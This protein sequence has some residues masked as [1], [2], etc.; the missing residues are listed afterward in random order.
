MERKRTVDEAEE[1]KAEVR[2]LHANPMVLVDRHLAIRYVNR[3]VPGLSA[4]EVLG[5]ELLEFLHPDYHDQARACIEGVLETG[6]P[7]SYEARGLGHHGEEALYEIHVS[8]VRHRGRITAATL[9]AHD[10]TKHHGLRGVVS[11][12]LPPTPIAAPVH[13]ALEFEE[14]FQEGQSASGGRRGRF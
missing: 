4:S 5:C 12:P 10:I 7:D 2:V 13:H 9:V 3:A 8:P 11:M 6:R 14:G 1:R